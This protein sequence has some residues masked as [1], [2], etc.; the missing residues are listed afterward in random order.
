LH[1]EVNSTNEA[2][3][4]LLAS[5]TAED[6]RQFEN[7]IQARLRHECRG[8]MNI[9]SRPSDQGPQFLALLQELAIQFLEPRLPMK[10]IGR[11]LDSAL[12]T[13]SKP[14]VRARELLAAAAPFGFGVLSRIDTYVGVP[15]DGREFGR[16][17]HELCPDENIRE[18]RSTDD[19]V[20]WRVCSGLTPDAFSYL[21]A[22]VTSGADGDISQ[23]RSAYS[24]IDVPWGLDVVT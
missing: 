17:L 16:R 18:T 23:T 11:I 7:L 1:D 8:V 15:D 4:R 2:A 9:C 24:R 5:L 13:S 14:E 12:A 19:V 20:I 22:N 21:G 6:A 3:G 10:N